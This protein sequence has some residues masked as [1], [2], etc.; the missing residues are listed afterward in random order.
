MSSNQLRTLN[1][2]PEWKSEE[3]INEV[4]EFVLSIQNGDNLK[5]PVSVTS[6]RDRKRYMEKFGTDFWVNETIIGGSI[7]TRNRGERTKIYSNESEN[8]PQPKKTKKKPKKTKPAVVKATVVEPEIEPEIEPETTKKTA[9][10]PTRLFYRPIIVG[11]QNDYRILNEIVYPKDKEIALTELYNDLSKGSAI[12][13]K[14]FYEQVAQHYLGFTREETTDFLRKQ[15]EYNISRPY[16][17]VVNRPVLAK[18]ANERW[19]MDLMEMARYHSKPKQG[20]TANSEYI[21]NLDFH[22]ENGKY[23]HI[24]TIVDFFSKKLWAV[25]LVSASSENVKNAFDDILRKTQTIPRIIQTDNGNEFISNAFQIYLVRL[26]RGYAFLR[27]KSNKSVNTLTIKHILTK[28][29]ASQSNGLIERMNEMLR[30]KIRD[31]FVR[32]NNLEWVKYLS[33]YVENINS[34]K[35]ARTK[36]TPNQLWTEGYVP[37]DT[38]LINTKIEITDNSSREDIKKYQQFRY[39]QRA[40]NQIKD[41]LRKDENETRPNTNFKVG[42]FV[43]IK[44]TAFPVE[45]AKKMRERHKNNNLGDVK[46]SAIKYTPMLYTI[47]KVLDNK[48][49][50]KKGENENDA[51]IRYKLLNSAK[52]QYTLLDDNENIVKEE[53]SNKKSRYFYKS[54]LMLI[55]KDSVPSKIDSIERTEQINRLKSYQ[56]IPFV[57]DN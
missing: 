33:D 55:P 41:D 2:Y 37:A 53:K 40:E 26:N 21:K 19:G 1:A 35:P 48:P 3:T 28:P 16:K 44:L 13:I 43:R 8:I 24:L 15:G 23:T 54:D 31:G 25:P 29:Y 14:A 30:A 20:Q 17:K 18:V 10:T 6:Y 11:T 32:H 22:N 9:I 42:D 27:K 49:K 36:F 56:Y 39:L 46:Y 52:V 50:R 4:R 38:N 7:T 5:Y 51:E 34:Q 57:D 12:G 45:I 47:K